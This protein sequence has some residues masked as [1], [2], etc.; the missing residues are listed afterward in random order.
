MCCKY[1]DQFPES[2][3]SEKITHTLIVHMEVVLNEND[4]LVM[5][6]NVFVLAGNQ[7][8][9]SWDAEDKTDSSSATTHLSTST[10]N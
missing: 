9:I 2:F 4:Q 5:N 1:E 3:I 6:L 8:G 10:N 7:W